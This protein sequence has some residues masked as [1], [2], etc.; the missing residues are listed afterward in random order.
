MRNIIILILLSIFSFVSNSCEKEENNN[1]EIP[2]WGEWS[3]ITA[4]KNGEIWKA[5]SVAIIDNNKD[6][7]TIQANVLNSSGYWRESLKLRCVPIK[8]GLFTVYRRIY[9]NDTKISAT[10]TTFS[11][12]GDVVEDRFVVLESQNNYIEIKQVDLTNME[13]SGTLQITFVR[14]SLDTVDNPS[15]GDTIFFTDGKFRLKIVE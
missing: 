15:L 4:L 2:E 13:M 12:D 10:Y 5:S 14:D 8:E 11:D 7:V 6:S 1:P 3:K 9:T